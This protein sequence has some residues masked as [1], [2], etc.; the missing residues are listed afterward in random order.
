M[1]V[2]E[3]SQDALVLLERGGDDGAARRV[4]VAAG[5]DVLDHLQG[6]LGTLVV[7]EFPVDHDDRRV[8]ARRVALDTLE[9]D[10]SVFAGLV[11]ADA[12]LLGDL[13]PDLVAAHDGAQRVRAHAHQVVA[14]GV[15]LVL[16]VEGRDGADLCAGQV[17][18]GGDEVDAVRADVA[19]DGLDQVQ[20]RQQR[21]ARVTVRVAGDDL[22]GVRLQAC[23][24]VGCVAHRSTP[25]RT[26]S[27]AAR[28]TT[29]S[30]SWPPSVIMASAC[31]LA[32]EGSRKCARNGRVPPSETR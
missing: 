3:A 4:D 32:K 31:R 10:L 8:V 12:D 5:L 13:F 15:A 1:P 23:Q 19:V 26:G 22:R 28:A 29:T 16:R 27:I 18:R 9:R 21:G 20:H 17:Q 30:A 6:R 25:P 2:Q 7:E 24:G 14:G 11:A